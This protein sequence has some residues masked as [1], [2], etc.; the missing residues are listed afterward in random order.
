[1]RWIQVPTRALEIRRLFGHV[2]GTDMGQTRVRLE[3]AED[4]SKIYDRGHAGR[5]SFNDFYT[6]F[7]DRFACTRLLKHILAP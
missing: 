3:L 2:T 4:L 7:S 5:R 1:M 6:F